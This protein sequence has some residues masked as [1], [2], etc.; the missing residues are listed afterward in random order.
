MQKNKLKPTKIARGISTNSYIKCK[1]KKKLIHHYKL[2]RF[3]Y[4]T[5]QPENQMFIYLFRTYRPKIRTEKKL[6]ITKRTK[7]KPSFFLCKNKH[8]HKKNETQRQQRR[9][10]RK[11]EVFSSSF[12]SKLKS[13]SSTSN[14]AKV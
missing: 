11:D 12:S 8:S 9:L 6:C 3:T 7:K 2:Y 4:K 1:R 13:T 5:C 10:K 14:N